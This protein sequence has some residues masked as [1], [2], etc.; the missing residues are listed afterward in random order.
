MKRIIGLTLMCLLGGCA[1]QEIKNTPLKP[2][3]RDTAPMPW[4]QVIP[5]ERAIEFKEIEFDY[6]AR[7]VRQNMANDRE[8]FNNITLVLIDYTILPAES[9]KKSQMPKNNKGQLY[10]KKF[11]EK[12]E[13]YFLRL[14]F[15]ANN[16]RPP[17]PPV[18]TNAETLNIQAAPLSEALCYM[19]NEATREY[20]CSS[21]RNVQVD[22]D[23]EPFEKPVRAP[24]SPHFMPHAPSFPYSRPY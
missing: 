1:T 23:V 3:L 5:S 9:P 10:C 24:S 7:H 17:A 2:S 12:P 13:R 16:T 22:L 8:V 20:I 11:I 14:S 18:F 19:V 6:I 15:Y 4:V 21:S